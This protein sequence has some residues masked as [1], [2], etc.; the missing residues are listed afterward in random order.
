MTTTPAA[1]VEA[2]AEPCVIADVEL[3][4]LHPTR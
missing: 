1:I 3:A 2:P 4:A